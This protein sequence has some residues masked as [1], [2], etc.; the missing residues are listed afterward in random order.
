MNCNNPGSYIGGLYGSAGGLDKILN[1]YTSVYAT[2]YNY[3]WSPTQGVIYSDIG[4][5]MG[6]A[7]KILRNAR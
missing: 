6:R 7:L 3:F 2:G 1:N 5:L 4:G